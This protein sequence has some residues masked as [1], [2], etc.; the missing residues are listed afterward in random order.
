MDLFGLPHSEQPELNKIKKELNLLQRLYKLY[1][2]VIDSVNNYHNIPWQEVNIEDINNELIQTPLAKPKEYAAA[3]NQF[4]IDYLDQSE[5]LDFV[6]S[7]STT[8]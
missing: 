4:V 2:D 5:L 1:N 3:L 8:S 6:D 7:S